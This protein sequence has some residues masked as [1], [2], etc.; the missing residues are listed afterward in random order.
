MSSSSA[1]SPEAVVTPP[2]AA[3]EGALGDPTGG[4]KEKGGGLVT[5]AWAA[6][7]M[8]WLGFFLIAPLVFVLHV[9]LCTYQPCMA[10]PARPRTSLSY[11]AA[12]PA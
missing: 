6:P 5:A 11:S 10:S 8:L 3:R 9:S 12:V 4:A 1:S 2:A 7:G